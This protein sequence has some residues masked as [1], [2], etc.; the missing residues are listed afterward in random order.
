MAGYMEIE[1]SQDWFVGWLSGHVEAWL[2]R[3]RESEE[4]VRSELELQRSIDP[5]VKKP[6]SA[7]DSDRNKNQPHRTAQS[8]IV[9]LC[10]KLAEYEE[11]RRRGQNESRSTGLTSRIAGLGRA[12]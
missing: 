7:E 1:C 10:A 5:P 4:R 6:G 3:E 8:D 2:R 11:A 9:F 12:G